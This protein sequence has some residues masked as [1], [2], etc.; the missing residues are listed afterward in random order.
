LSLQCF[1]LAATR[2]REVMDGATSTVASGRFAVGRSI[3]FQ[4]TLSSS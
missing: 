3:L 2:H 4:R 1:L